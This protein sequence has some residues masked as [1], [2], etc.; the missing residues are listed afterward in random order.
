LA[1]V[2][3]EAPDGTSLIFPLVK[4]LTSLGRSAENDIALAFAGMPD[5]ALHFELAGDELRLVGHPGTDFSLNGKRR[6]EGRLQQGDQIA[7]AGAKINVN[8]E[9]APSAP[10]TDSGLLTHPSQVEAIRTL[11]RFSQRMMQ[12]EDVQLV[13]E[14]MM[15]AAISLTRAEKGFLLLAEGDRMQVKV[16]R[17]LPLRPGEG[18]SSSRSLE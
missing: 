16:A 15:D 2:V 14:E 18:G 12:Q 13:L 1:S 7:L 11:V 6:A 9:A 17:N 10:K 3:I 8:L 4:R 5:S